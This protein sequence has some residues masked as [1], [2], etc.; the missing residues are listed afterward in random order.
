MNGCTGKAESAK[1]KNSNDMLFSRNGLRFDLC[2]LRFAPLRFALCALPFAS[3]RFA[4]FA[5]FAP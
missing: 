5:P 3:F 2:A 4:P 1:L